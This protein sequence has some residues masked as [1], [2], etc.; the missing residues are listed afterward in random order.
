MLTFHNQRVFLLVLCTRE[1][2]ASSKFAQEINEWCEKLDLLKNEL[3]TARTQYRL[4]KWAAV[5]RHDVLVFN[6]EARSEMI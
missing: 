2:T 6:M 4:E 1:G 3:I 5:G